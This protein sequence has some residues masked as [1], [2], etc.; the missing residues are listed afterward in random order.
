MNNWEKFKYGLDALAVVGTWGAVYVALRLS[1]AATKKTEQDAEARAGL[2]AARHLA[3]LQNLH[4]GARTL[5]AALIA[6]RES[7][8]TSPALRIPLPSSWLENLRAVDLDVL[9]Q[10]LPLPNYC[11]SRIGK[12][13]GELIA[14]IGQ[15]EAMQGTWRSQNAPLRAAWL[16]KWSAR[17]G[18]TAVNL[19]IAIEECA[20]AAKT[21]A[22]DFSA[23]EL[24][25]D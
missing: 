13:I 3:H 2:V 9:A 1:R 20:K 5:S 23:T 22:P 16:D 10:L 18:S 8:A 4:S 25:L 21:H 14:I 19:Q 17:A 24:G 7:M 11:A 6:Y 12:A 15:M